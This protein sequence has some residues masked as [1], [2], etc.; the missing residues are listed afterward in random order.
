MWLWGRC[1]RWAGPWVRCGHL[2]WLWG[3]CDQ[4]V[5]PWDRCGYLVWILGTCGLWA[6]PWVRCGQWCGHR[7]GVACDMAMGQVWLFGADFGQVWPVVWPWGRCGHGSRVAGGVATVGE[8]HGVGEWLLRRG[9]PALV[10]L[11]V[12]QCPA[13]LRAQRLQCLQPGLGGHR[14]SGGSPGDTWDPQPAPGRGRTC[15][16][17]SLL[18][19]ALAPS[20]PRSFRRRNLRK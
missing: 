7:A 13:H 2:V 5:R 18:G 15:S 9:V 4:W 11:Q 19:P 1:D 14:G 6:R 8:A 10:P 20:I 12:T 16:A 17:H 3:R